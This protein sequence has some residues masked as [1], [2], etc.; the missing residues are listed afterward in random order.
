MAGTTGK[1][2]W[3]E[4]TGN[5]GRLDWCLIGFAIIGGMLVLLP[6]LALIN[7]TLG[8]LADIPY[9]LAV[10]TQKQVVDSIVL[11]FGAGLLAVIILAIFGTPLSYVLARTNSRINQVVESLVDLPL[12][13]PHTVAGLM[14][15]ILF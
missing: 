15:Y 1:H 3:L 13:L 12:V 2:R 14:V 9:L 4:I 11:T 6:L 7:I 8:Q 10:A 5:A